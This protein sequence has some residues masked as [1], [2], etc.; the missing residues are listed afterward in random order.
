MAR[1]CHKTPGRLR[2]ADHRQ[3]ISWQVRTEGIVPLWK[4]CA[5]HIETLIRNGTLQPGEALP[6][7]SEL[8]EWTGVGA[9]TL[10]KAMAW[11]KAE[12]LLV[13]HRHRGTFVAENPHRGRDAWVAVLTRAM[14]DPGLSQWDH[15]AARAVVDVLADAGARFRFYHNAYMPG[16]PSPVQQDIDPRLPEDVEAGRVRGLLVI[17][18]VPVSHPE[19]REQL[20]RANVPA[21]ETTGR[22][23]RTPYVVEFDR[24]AFVRRAVERAAAKGCRRLA[25]VETPGFEPNGHDL[26]EEAFVAA[27]KRWGLAVATPCP[28][29]IP[30]MPSAAKGV[31]AF[32][33]LWKA[34]GPRPDGLV[35]TDEYVALGA[36]QAAVAAG[37]AVPENSGW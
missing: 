17:G 4:Q 31:A 29:R 22:G 21:V 25:L 15:L 16:R 30:W 19:L 2:V 8:A 37:A 5:T 7:H 23:S 20:R 36:A 3:T 11:L 6:A 33:H 32:D 27:T 12:G 9:S 34:A 1:Q 14:F 18:G 35:I 26:L 10:Q 28:L 13:R 24:L